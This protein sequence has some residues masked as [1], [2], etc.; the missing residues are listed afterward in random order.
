M[1]NMD[2]KAIRR[3][4]GSTGWIVLIYYVLINVCAV[5]GIAFEAAAAM[6]KSASFGIDAMM[7]AAMD[8]ATSAWGYVA[9]MVIGMIILFAWKKR[10]FWREQIWAKGR[11]MKCGD[12]FGILVI[13]LSA[14]LVYQFYVMAL[15]VGLNVF[16]LSMLEGLELMAST[17]DSFSMFLYIGILAPI[18]EEILCRGLVLRTL[19]PF[20]KKF[21]IFASAFLFGMFHGNILQVPFAFLVGLVLGYVA[22]EYSI[23]W[24]MILHMINNLVLGDMLTRLIPG[25]IASTVVMWVVLVICAVAAIIVVV[26]RR[27]EITAWHRSSA[28]VPGVYKRFFGSGGVITFTVLMVLSMIAT[29]FTLITPM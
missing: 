16:G 10:K 18:V 29:C 20:G 7:D 5:A 23:A 27:D 26:R 28:V 3:R 14:Q 25:E 13:F 11:P 6:V 8:A 22:A 19:M 1:N 12:F 15:E 17:S 9:A 24:A 4:V 2:R 21:A